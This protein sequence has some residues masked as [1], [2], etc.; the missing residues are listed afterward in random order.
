MG[1]IY[2]GLLSYKVLNTVLHVH[3][4]KVSETNNQDTYSA[5]R[6]HGGRVVTLSPPTSEVWVQFPARPVIGK[7]V[8][9]CYWSVVYS[10]EP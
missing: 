5:E 4:E 3:F 2:L 8:V 10:T 9:A 7:L 6:N 1:L